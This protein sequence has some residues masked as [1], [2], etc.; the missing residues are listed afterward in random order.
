MRPLM[1]MAI[2][3]TLYTLARQQNSFGRNQAKRWWESAAAGA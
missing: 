1:Q 3:E 2:L